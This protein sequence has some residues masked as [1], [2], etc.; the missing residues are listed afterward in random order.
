MF[1]QGQ[2]VYFNSFV[3]KNGNDPKPK[4]FIILKNL[5]DTTIIGSLPTRTNTAPSFI[6]ISH[7]CINLDE[8]C[9]NCYLFQKDKI[10]CQ[11]GFSFDLPTY[12]YGDQIEDYEVEKLEEMY[13]IRGVDYEILDTLNEDEYNAIINCLLNSQ[14]V[15]RKIKKYLQ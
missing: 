8:R 12:I 7:G 11:N 6:T 13:K 3:F 14:S 4:Y 10:I 5:G 9:Y 1:L 15:K 2:V